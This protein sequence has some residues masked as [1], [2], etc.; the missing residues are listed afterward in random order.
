MNICWAEFSRD[1]EISTKCRVEAKKNTMLC[2]LY[3]RTKG[4]R[5]M[6]C[7][8]DLGIY[9]IIILLG[10]CSFLYYLVQLNSNIIHHNNS[11]THFFDGI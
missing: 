5:L 6:G 2:K 9:H 8:T 3:K 11:I 1:L 7:N 10:L 4:F